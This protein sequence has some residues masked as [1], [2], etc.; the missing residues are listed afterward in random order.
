MSSGQTGAVHKDANYTVFYEHFTDTV[1]PK[2]AS[3]SR[4]YETKRD[5]KLP[6]AN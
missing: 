4:V 6:V 5:T 3:Y 2:S 1:T